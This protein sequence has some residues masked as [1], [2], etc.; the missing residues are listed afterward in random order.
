[1][2]I[3]TKTKREHPVLFPGY[4][5]DCP[6]GHVQSYKVFIGNVFEILSAKLIEGDVL[7]MNCQKE[8]NPD[9]MNKSKKILGES[10]ATN[11][12]SELKLRHDQLEKYKIAN[13]YGWDVFYIIWTYNEFRLNQQCETRREMLHKIIDSIA[14]V[15]VLD[16]KVVAALI[17]KTDEIKGLKTYVGNRWSRFGPLTLV[18]PTFM[19]SLRMN[20][21][22]PLRALE[23]GAYLVE[24]DDR[25]IDFK[26]NGVE[27]KTPVFNYTR[28]KKL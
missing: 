10:K 28:I 26:F 24:V 7:T 23:K 8:C 2:R 3:N 4:Q 6:L 1:M 20:T 14:F 9:I 5:L 17:K 16:V 13:G 25:Q 22:A 18:K 19:K 21:L 27:F 12:I 11:H 15:E